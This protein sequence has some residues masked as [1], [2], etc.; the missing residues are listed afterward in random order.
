[1]DGRS[2]MSRTHFHTD[3]YS[4]SGSETTLMLLLDAAA[5]RGDEFTFTYRRWP[6]YEHG[7][8]RRLPAGVRARGLRLPDPADVKHAVTGGRPGT[9]ARLVRGAITLLPF[10]QLFLA[11]DTVRLTALLRKERPDVLHVNNGGLPGSISCNAAAIAGRLAGVPV[12]VMVVN[13][14]AFAYNRPGRWFDY[15]VDRLLVRSVTR[16]VTG[17][18]AAGTALRRVLRLPEGQHVVIPNGVEQR[19]PTASADETRSA[20]GLSPGI[21][22]VSV[23]ARLEARKGHRHL[24]D[25]LRLLPADRRAALRVLFAGA[26]PERGRL[27][28]EVTRLGLT[29]VVQFLGDHPDP[30]SL[31]E[32]SDLVVLPSVRH[33][34]LPI[35][36]MEAMAAGVPAVASRVAGTVELIEAGVTGLLVEPAEPRQLADAIAGLL[37]DPDRRR[38]M[39][40]AAT[41]RYEATYTPAQAVAAY[42]D[43]TDR[44]LTG[45]TA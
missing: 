37:D 1:V 40:K 36:L 33:E 8:F 31:Y 16:F 41:L 35:V 38:A 12:V 23:V 29:D 26:G 17:S 45:V 6:E 9:G 5:R 32:V 2:P 42:R 20:L 19:L 14:L 44:L 43:L 28:Q 24:L 10:R 7:L 3:C 30:W 34:D 21:A 22:V 13:N 4:F 11:Y 39:G 27:E 25:A 18:A 15:P